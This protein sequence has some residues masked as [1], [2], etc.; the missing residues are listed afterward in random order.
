M[1]PPPLMRGYSGRPAML[2][3]LLSIPTFLALP[4]GAAVYAR[5]CAREGCFGSALYSGGTAATMLTAYGLASAAF[6]QA[7]ALVAGGGLYLRAATTT[8]VAW[9][10]ALA[11]HTHRT[12]ASIPNGLAAARRK[13]RTEGA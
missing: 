7:P 2:H 10:T 12:Q 11:V 9:F 1:H 5:S 8:D 13:P 3:E 4:A 6:N